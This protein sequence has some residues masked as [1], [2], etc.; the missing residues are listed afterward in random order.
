MNATKDIMDQR[1]PPS[2]VNRVQKDSIKISL[3][4]RYAPTAL[5]DLLKATKLRHLV[6]RAVQE[7]IQKMMVPPFARIA[8]PA[9][10]LFFSNQYDV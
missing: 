10:W 1:Q 2:F 6:V 5:Q 7:P 9:P 4:K 8:S 3:L